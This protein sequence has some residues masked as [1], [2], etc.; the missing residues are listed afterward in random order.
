MS[1]RPLKLFCKIT[2][3]PRHG[4]ITTAPSRP[5]PACA[6]NLLHY[7]PTDI[8]TIVLASIELKILIS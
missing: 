2:N 8:L 6:P 1:S 3:F 5:I 4:K 7:A